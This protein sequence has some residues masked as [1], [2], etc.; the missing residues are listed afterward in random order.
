MWQ[1]PSQINSILMSYVIRTVNGKIIVLDGGQSPETPYLK[2]FLDR[3]GGN[4]EAWFISHPHDDH[5]NAL[6]EILLDPGD[7]KIKKIY[8]SLPD[9]EWVRQVRAGWRAE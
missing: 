5:C 2:S 1:L 4:V 9:E 6:K 8:A 3:F 7:I